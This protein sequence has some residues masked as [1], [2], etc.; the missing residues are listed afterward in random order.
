[1]KIEPTRPKW[2]SKSNVIHLFHSS[3]PIL[4]SANFNPS[5]SRIVSQ[6]KAKRIDRPKDAGPTSRHPFACQVHSGARYGT[7]TIRISI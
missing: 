2:R 5:F 3:H 4:H 7:Q 1:M 6:L